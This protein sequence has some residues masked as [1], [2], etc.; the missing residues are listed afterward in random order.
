MAQ[1]QI[2]V[3]AEMLHGLFRGDEGVAKLLESVRNQVHHEQVSEQLKAAPCERTDEREGYRN[4]YRDREM[5]TRVGT[6]ELRIP[7]VRNGSFSTELFNRYQRSEQALLLALMEMV[8][9][10]VSTRKVRQIT[11]EL[12]GTS[13]SKSTVSELCKALDPVVSAWNGRSLSGTSFPFVV[14]DAMQIKV[15]KNGRVVPQSASIVAGVNA[16]GHRQVVG[17]MLG[18]SDAEA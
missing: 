16:E 7:R 8:I 6:L 9:N 1:Y 13:F 11:E 14:V 18:S 15:R 10:G 3:D 17:L 2:T 12:C 5:K 4:G